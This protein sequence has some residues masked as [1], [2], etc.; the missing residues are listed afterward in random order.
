MLLSLRKKRILCYYVCN[1]KESTKPFYMPSFRA[2]FV[3]FLSFVKASGLKSHMTI[4]VMGLNPRNTVRRVFKL[5]SWGDP[6]CTPKW[7]SN[8]VSGKSVSLQHKYFPVTGVILKICKCTLTCFGAAEKSLQ[9][10]TV[11][12]SSED[13]TGSKSTL[14]TNTVRSSN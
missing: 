11:S 14:G 8:M 1:T 10:K 7:P 3:H 2:F 9:L 6:H 4:G 12:S 13:L 5:L